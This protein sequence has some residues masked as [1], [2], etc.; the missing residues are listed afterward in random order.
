M[1]SGRADL[2]EITRCVLQAE[3]AGGEDAEAPPPAEDL[4][5]LFHV[6]EIHAT[7]ALDVGQPVA[8]ATDLTSVLAI[9]GRQ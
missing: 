5:G 2:R 3:H 7:D 8:R 9:A 1:A 6:S 4:G